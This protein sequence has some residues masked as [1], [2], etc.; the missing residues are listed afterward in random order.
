MSNRCGCKK[1]IIS[2]TIANL[3]NSNCSDNFIDECVDVCT[4]PNCGEPYVLNAVIPVIYD[5]IGINVCRSFSVAPYL[6]TYPS[7][8]YIEAEV[9][10]LNNPAGTTTP[11]SITQI[12]NRP[13]CYEINLINL[14]ATFVLKFYD[15]YKRLLGTETIND[16]LYLPPTA[17]TPG[18]DPD[19]NPTGVT[20]ELFAPYGI[21]YGTST[22][23]PNLNFVG[24]LQTNQGITQGLNMFAIPKVLDF[25]TMSETIT[26]GLTVIVNSIY[27]AQYR[28]P[29]DGKV[30]VPKGELTGSDESVCMNFVS[31]DLLD[32]NIKPLEQKKY[33]DQKNNCIEADVNP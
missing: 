7:T 29:H 5:E 1:R 23:S 22:A 33:C 16:I 11:I 20:L 18:Y 15:H 3:E 2:N 27:Y 30:I 9:V 17:A 10:S 4:T 14:N 13:R 21:S 31:G 24:L 25:D 6:T 19:T 26:V 32:R 8:A 28:L 12:P